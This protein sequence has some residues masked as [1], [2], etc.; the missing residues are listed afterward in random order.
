[1][2]GDEIG[3]HTRLPFHHRFGDV[4]GHVRCQR[5]ECDGEEERE[6]AA[7]QVVA[8]LGEG[9]QQH[10]QG[11]DGADGRNVIEEQMKMYEVHEAFSVETTA[12]RPRSVLS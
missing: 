1:M 10:A 4:T 11:D 7:E 9:Q 6:R 2:N 5:D 3:V 12:D 8:L